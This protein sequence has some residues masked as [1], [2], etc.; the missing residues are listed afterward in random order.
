[1]VNKKQRGVKSA[2]VRELL[3]QNPKMSVPDVVAALEAR[4]ISVTRNLVYLNKNK[5]RARRRR[6]QRERAMAAGRNA[7]IANP[8]ELVQKVKELAAA[9]G[10][11]KILKQ[12]VE[13]LGG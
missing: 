5:M 1:M 13:V 3:E 8:A 10:G 2:A 4:G 6:Q 11:M 12:L 7:G 9:A